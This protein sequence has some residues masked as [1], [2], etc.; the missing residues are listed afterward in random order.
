MVQCEADMLSR[1]SWE[2]ADIAMLAGH[3][4][5]EAPARHPPSGSRPTA[6]WPSRP[7]AAGSEGERDRRSR[8]VFGRLLESGEM[9]FLVVPEAREFNRIPPKIEGQRARQVPPT[10]P[11]FVSQL[12]AADRRRS[13]IARTS[14]IRSST[15]RSAGLLPSKARCGLTSQTRPSAGGYT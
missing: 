10:A 9:R 8:E 2:R 14:S 5:G 13:M 4:L 12:Y 6:S 7:C 1:V 3:R 11:P 15:M